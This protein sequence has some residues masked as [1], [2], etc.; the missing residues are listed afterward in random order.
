MRVKIKQS[1]GDLA[2]DIINTV[3]LVLIMLVILYPLYFIVIASLS[4]PLEVLAGKVILYPKNFSVDAYG[5][6]FKDGNIMTG[7]R[8][9]L[10]YTVFGTAIN[11]ALSVLAAYPLSRRD[12]VGKKFF[13]MV[14]TITMFFSGGMIPL[15]LTVSSLGLLD[16]IWAILLPGAISVWN[17]VIIRTYFQT[18][19]PFEL[20]E[21]AMVDGATNFQLLFRVI[22][23]LSTPVIAVMVLFYGVA[24]WNAFFNALIYISSK[25]LYPLQLVLRSI[26]IQNTPSDEMMADLDNAASRQL[27]AETIKYALI[28][29]AT[30]PIIAVYP[31]LQKYF[32][33]G[34]M[35]G[36]VKG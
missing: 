24:H 22:L 20:T 15:Y 28:V 33:K 4:D 29:V 23:P 21:A 16:T 25:Q 12:F 11:I 17:V 8:N 3:L 19:I 9:T 13:T 34:I 10:F 2:F 36:A 6:V 27:L 14:L 5:M 31:F 35:V 1:R 18:S 7:Y 26:L 32:V 30:A